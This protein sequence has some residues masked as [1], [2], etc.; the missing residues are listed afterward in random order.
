M[1]TVIKII[2]VDDHDFYREALKLHFSYTKKYEVI[3]EASN[4]EEFLKLLEKELPDVVLMDINMPKMNG[5]EATK[6]S[7]NYYGKAMKIIALTMHEEFE[8]L[9]GMI[10]AG[11]SGY[12]YKNSMV[13]Q[14]EH[15]ID[16]VIGGSLY[17]QKGKNSR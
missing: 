10:E 13:D 9:K 1:D 11:I 4:G 6:L 15:A 8:Y 3:G 14:L 5:E 16:V 7:V 17:F 12:L 2:I